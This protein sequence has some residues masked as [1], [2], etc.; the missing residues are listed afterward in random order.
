LLDSVVGGASAG[1]GG[2]P[3]PRGNG[4]FLRFGIADIAP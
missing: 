2:L 4:S 3:R 1:F